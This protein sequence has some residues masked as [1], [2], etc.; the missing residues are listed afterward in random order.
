MKLTTLKKQAQHSAN[1]R[2]HK[3]R[4]QNPGTLTQLGYCRKCGKEVL[5][6][7]SPAPNEIHIGGEALALGCDD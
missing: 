6:N 4:W 3:M 5:L 1:W 7:T 2:G